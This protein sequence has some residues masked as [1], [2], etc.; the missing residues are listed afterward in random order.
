M[1]T[2]TLVEYKKKLTEAM[3][4]FDQFCSQNNLNYFACSGTAIGAIRH[5]GFIPWDD[6]IDVLMLREDYQKLIAIRGELDGSGYS[7][8]TLGDEEYIYSYAKFIDDNTTLIEMSS[9]PK[10][11]IGVFIDIF[12]L[13]EVSGDI[14]DIKIKKLNY[15]F[16]YRDFQ[17]TFQV[18]SLR[19]FLSSLYHMNITRL[20]NLF[21]MRL[22]R[23]GDKVKNK[24]RD[25]F[26]E[27]DKEWSKDKGEFIM[28]HACL[29]KVEKEIFKKEWFDN[30]LYVEFENIKI[31]IPYM[32]DEYLTQLFGDYMTPPPEDKRGSTHKHY[33]LNLRE[34]LSIEEVQDRIRRGEVELY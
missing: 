13:D 32:Y 9:F 7:I 8:K 16:A 4:T 2:E 6:D 33:Y 14:Q 20:K 34:R 31:R 22:P 18:L 29:Y 10:C 30:Y 19:P 23:I 3:K 12:P 17:D 26:I 15:N 27:Y 1:T 11:L 28:S 25:A 5:K 24:L 21:L